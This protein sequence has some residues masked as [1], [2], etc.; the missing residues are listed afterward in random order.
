M[1]LSLT[2]IGID[3]DESIQA[4]LEQGVLIVGLG[5]AGGQVFGQSQ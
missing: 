2:D 3:P 4:N 5:Q 1:T